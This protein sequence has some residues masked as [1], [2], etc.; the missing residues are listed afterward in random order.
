MGNNSGDAPRGG[1]KIG[2]VIAII[3]ATLIIAAL[4]AAITYML[5]TNEPEE[6]T[7][8]L[9]SEP[10]E[11]DM[12]AMI[13][14]A[15]EPATELKRPTAWYGNFESAGP[16]ENAP[17][18]AAYEAK[19]PAVYAYIVIPGTTISYPIAYCEDAVN[20]YYFTHDIDGNE[21]ETGMIITDSMNAA[22]LSDPMTLIYGHA[23]NDGTMFAPLSGFR[24]AGFFGTHE[25]VNIYTADAQ[26][27]YR[28]Y[29][30]YI[31]SSDHILVDND[32]SD[33]ASFTKYIDSVSE[34]RDLSMNL[35]QDAKPAVGD[36]VIALITHCGDESKRLFVLAVLDEVR[37]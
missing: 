29:A 13:E 33:P 27:K 22:D 24:D 15:E 20:P 35:R 3:A 36:H 14:A 30:C 23:P 34:V 31:G 5:A 32:F 4:S 2:I 1:S 25:Y 11:F 21:S 10:A 18:L 37:Y 8:T 12:E 17:D 9:Q 6:E 7:V 19:C 28:I 16:P 26:L